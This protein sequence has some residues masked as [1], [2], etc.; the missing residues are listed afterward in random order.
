MVEWRKWLAPVKDGATKALIRL[1]RPSPPM[2]TEEEFI[3]PLREELTA[4]MAVKPD[5]GYGTA[6]AH[7]NSHKTIDEK[8]AQ[9][10]KDKEDVHPFLHEHY[11]L[12]REH[13]NELRTTRQAMRL[14]Q[15]DISPKSRM[16]TLIGY[17]VAGLVMKAGADAFLQ[18]VVP[19][20]LAVIP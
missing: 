13:I 5:I 20:L 12:M 18:Y 10:L 2:P 11:A 17:A 19:Y 16:Q 1:R 8:L 6:C 15:Q 4:L 7:C 14:V 3:S 9:A